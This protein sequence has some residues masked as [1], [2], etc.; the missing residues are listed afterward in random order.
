MTIHL[1]DDF[2]PGTP[3]FDPNCDW[4]NTVGRWLNNLSIPGF[5]KEVTP[6]SVTFFQDSAQSAIVVPGAWVSRKEAALTIGIQAGDIE[7]GPDDVIEWGDITG[8]ALTVAVSAGAS[9]WWVW[10]NVNT[11]DMTAEML[12]GSA[13]IALTTSPDGGERYYMRQKRICKATI[14]ADVI[15]TVIPCQFG[16]I[17]I[18]RAAG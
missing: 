15:Q 11:R 2:A 13:I 8:A 3:V 4:L 14:T 7:L 6:Y 1:K 18:P 10:V 12:N 9:V 16:N 17:D 5:R